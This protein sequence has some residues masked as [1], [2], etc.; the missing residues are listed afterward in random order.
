MPRLRA[1]VHET[2]PSRTSKP[3]TRRRKR[4]PGAAT[5][6]HKQE[7]G[8]AEI[9]RGEVDE[10]QRAVDL[11]SLNSGEVAGLPRLD[12][13]GDEQASGGDAPKLEQPGAPPA[14]PMAPDAVLALADLAVQVTCSVVGRGVEVP[15]QL[16]SLSETE[17]ALLAPFSVGAAR[18]LGDY[19]QALEKYSGLIFVGFLGLFVYQRV[20]TLRALE[21]IAPTSNNEP[22]PAAAAAPI[23][24]PGSP[25]H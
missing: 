20:R 19:S 7:A 12:L 8:G 25:F 5:T 6:E 22:T 2:R 15:A 13:S 16:R 18:Q 10:A 21:P 24:L 3:S 17:R 14:E 1:E 9:S 11:E 4:A 23:D